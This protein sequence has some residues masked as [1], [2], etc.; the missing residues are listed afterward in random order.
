MTSLAITCR[1]RTARNAFPGVP[2]LIGGTPLSLP[3]LPHKALP[4]DATSIAG[5]REPENV[6]P[7]LST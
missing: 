4:V 1:E 3:P 2:S 7:A 6:L 5:E